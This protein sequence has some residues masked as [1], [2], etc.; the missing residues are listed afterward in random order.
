MGI[1][2]LSAFLIFA[3]LTFD[4]HGSENILKKDWPTISKCYTCIQVQYRSLGFDIERSDVKK[5]TLLDLTSPV[6]DLQL[7]SDKTKKGIAIVNLTPANLTEDFKSSGYFT[8]LGIKTN[9]DF[10]EALGKD[11]PERHPGQIMRKVMEVDTAGDYIHY[12]KD[13]LDAF[14]IKSRNPSSQNVYLL[15]E[16]QTDVTLIGGAISPQILSQILSTLTISH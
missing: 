7:N 8:E 6:L 11:Y 13:G 10:F 1:K 14:W 2:Y 5:I 16:G 4:V 9:R 15:I 12:E 3:L